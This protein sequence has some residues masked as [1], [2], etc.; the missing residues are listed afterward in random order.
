M[1]AKRI[2]L[3]QLLYLLPL[4]IHQLCIFQLPHVLHLLN[5]HFGFELLVS[6]RT[7]EQLPSVQAADG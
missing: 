4:Y 3:S 2:H 6:L 5:V 7:I 1:H